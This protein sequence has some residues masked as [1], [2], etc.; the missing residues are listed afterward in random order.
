MGF[1]GPNGAGKSTTQKMLST[2][3]QP[4]SGEAKVLGFDLVAQQEQIQ[5]ERWMC[6]SSRRSR[7]SVYGNGKPGFSGSTLR[8]RRCYSKKISCRILRAFPDD[9]VCGPSSF[10]LFRRP[11]TPIGHCFGHDSSSAAASP[12]RTHHGS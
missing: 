6:Q 5:A 11:K 8:H 9:L 10:Y 7:F 12:R 3:M 1:L 2:L 4:T